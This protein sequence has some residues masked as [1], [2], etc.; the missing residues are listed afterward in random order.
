MIRSHFALMRAARE[1]FALNL[2]QYN[3]AEV[4]L[5]DPELLNDKERRERGQ[6]RYREQ[7]WLSFGPW[8]IG[9][10]AAEE[11]PPLGTLILRENNINGETLIEGPY[12]PATWAAIAARINLTHQLFCGASNAPRI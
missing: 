2:P 3:F 1:F 10:F 5:R 6:G 11:R 9:I 7:V 12:A 8:E 4:K